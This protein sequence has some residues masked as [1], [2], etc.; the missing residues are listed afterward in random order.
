[1]YIYSNKRTYSNKR[2]LPWSN[3]KFTLTKNNSNKLPLP[4][5]HQGGGGGILIDAQG[6]YYNI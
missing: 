6:V 2:I 5:Q 4:L 3:I 1:M